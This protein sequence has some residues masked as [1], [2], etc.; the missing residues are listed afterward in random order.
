[1]QD[2]PLA[3]SVSATNWDDYKGGIFK[4]NS[5]DKVNHAVLLVGYDQNSWIIKNQWGEKW[6]EN[7]YIRVT[8]DRARN[9][10]VGASAFWMWESTQTFTL[11]GMLFVLIAFQF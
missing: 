6:G 8:K 5:Y 11:I 4:C 2:G 10:K 1:M 9:C 7:G 3:I